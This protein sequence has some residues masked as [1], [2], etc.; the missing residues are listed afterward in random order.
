ME[1]GSESD[2]PAP[3]RNRMA[4]QVALAANENAHFKEKFERRKTGSK[5]DMT[6]RLVFGG[7][8]PL[9]FGACEAASYYAGPADKKY[10]YESTIKLPKMLKDMLFDL[11]EY[12]D[13]DMQKMKQ[14]EPWSLSSLPWPTQKDTNVAE[15]EGYINQQ[16]VPTSTEDIA[17]CTGLYIRLTK[18]SRVEILNMDKLGEVELQT[19]Y[20][21]AL[22][23][24]LIADQDNNVALRWPNKLVDEEQ[25]EVKP[26][27]SFTT[28]HSVSH[29]VLRLGIAS[30]RAI[31]KRN[32][33]FGFKIHG[34]D[35]T[36]FITKKRHE[37]CYTLLEIAQF[38]YAS[39][40]SNLHSFVSMMNLN[41]LTKVGRCFWNG[42]Q[43]THVTRDD[44]ANAMTNDDAGA[45]PVS[46]L[47]ALINRTCNRT[48][49]A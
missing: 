45:V 25:T 47:Y 2:N 22:L 26:G 12:V 20:Y 43:A 8:Q 15:Y 7:G 1:S 48:L 14:I 6:I 36:F 11:Y 27:N 10:Y 30:K 34:F 4:R 39:S 29:D 46:E 35:L 44:E 41:K 24:E 37:N 40:L 16:E 21:D 28:K 5:P 23:S 49:G 42:C 3:V 9:E 33:C 32:S 38:T 19:T 13:W 31:D 18:V 17:N